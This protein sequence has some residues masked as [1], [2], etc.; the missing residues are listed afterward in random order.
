MVNKR[1]C[2]RKW[3]VLHNRCHHT[4]LSITRHCS[5]WDT[6]LVSSD[7]SLV[8]SDSVVG[9]GGISGGLSCSEEASWLGH[10]A[11]M[12]DDHLCPAHGTRLRRRD[13]VRKDIRKF[14][15]RSHRLSQPLQGRRASSVTMALLGSR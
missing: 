5:G 2:S 14:S 1:D 11:R 9:G 4:I 6:S 7:S 3:E 13:K 10:V 12:E 15:R 8:S